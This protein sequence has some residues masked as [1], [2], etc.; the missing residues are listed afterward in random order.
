MKLFINN[1][2]NN[3]HRK[4]WCGGE[5]VFVSILLNRS[6]K[7]NIIKLWFEVEKFE[8]WA[9]PQAKP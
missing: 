8:W 5:V 3:L 9:D 2:Q 4:P 7:F 1:H 6:I